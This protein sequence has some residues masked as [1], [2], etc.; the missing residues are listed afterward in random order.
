VTDR[1]QVQA[2]EQF[3]FVDQGN[4]TYV[5]QTVSGYYLGK[6]NA[7]PGTAVGVFSTNISD[8]KNATKFRLGMVL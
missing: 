3:R 6:T 2:W 4:C 7:A 5:I 8:I 1:T